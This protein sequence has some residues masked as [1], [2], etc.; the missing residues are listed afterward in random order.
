MFLAAEGMK[1]LL[2]GELLLRG[3][4]AFPGLII[5]DP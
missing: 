1:V 4:V 3:R 5:S 2:E